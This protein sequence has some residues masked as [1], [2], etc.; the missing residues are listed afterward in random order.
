MTLK[1]YRFTTKADAEFVNT[2]RKR[3]EAY[4]E[5][6]KITRNAD[7]RVHA[8][9]IIVFTIALAP[10]VIMMT[11][12]ITNMWA[13]F[14][15]WVIMGLGMAGIGTNVMHDALHGAYSSKPLVNKILGYSM[16]IVGASATTWKIQHNMLHH[17]FTNI[18]HADEDIDVPS[19][20]RFTP[21]QERKWIHRF[22][23]R[24]A[25]LLYGLLTFSWVTVA[26]FTSLFRYKKKGLV[27]E[28]EDFR[29]KFSYVTL[30]K[31]VY[32]VYI[33][34][35]PAIFIPAPFWAILLMFFVMHFVMGVILSAT[36]QLAHVVETTE[37]LDE[38]EDPTFSYSWHVHQLRTTANFAEKSKIV[39]WYTGGLNFQVEHHLFPHI[40]HIHYPKIAPIVAAT[41]KEFGVPYHSLGSLKDALRSHTSMLRQLGIAD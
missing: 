22:Q 39:T 37:I 36:F 35:L 7:W 13:L 29:K 12:I 19:V 16:N 40:C 2:L 9:T 15:L 11:G 30:W 28:G 32:F 26:D 1:R 4:F 38:K 23:H 25:W 21:F 3:V 8:K 20:L 17:S 14:G 31:V 41:A 6:N 34:V 10:L 24:Y 27:Q 33:L 5:D 18:N